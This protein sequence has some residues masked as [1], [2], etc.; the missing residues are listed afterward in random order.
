VLD[1]TFTHLFVLWSRIVN[2]NET[3]SRRL[4]MLLAALLIVAAGTS[5]PATIAASTPV[6]TP[7]PPAA[8]APEDLADP[9]GAF[10]EIDGARIYYVA[11]GPEDG[12]P[13]IL[14]HGLLGSTLTWTATTEALA[15][16][17]YRV[18]AFDQPPFGLSAKAS[19]LDYSVV[20]QA[21]RTIGLMDA[22]GIERAALVGHSGGGPIAGSV[23]ERY[24][25]RVSKLVLV[26]PAYLGLLFAPAGG[27]GSPAATPP[28]APDASPPV[29]RQ[30]SLGLFPVL[31]DPTND[32][33]SA[34]DQARLREA[35]ATEQA[36]MDQTTPA[37]SADQDPFRFTQIA[38]WE[39]GLL[40]HGRAWLNDPAI[41]GPNAEAITAP[42]LLIWGEGD[43]ISA[44]GDQLLALFS[45]AERV[46]VPGVG[47]FPMEEAPDAFNRAL[48]NFL[49]D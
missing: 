35:I 44:I 46:I 49:A 42:V 2:L 18:L 4:L 20:A 16:A 14:L 26:A 31:F 39:A 30:P 5:W 37:V 13:V 27:E 19:D 45:D 3:S 24:P 32:P 47:H 34:A 7:S 41:M 25:D 28:A 38:G 17:G 22:L 29:G 36:L 33:H 9:Q 10:I 6:A 21:D 48:L 12:P 1:E 11:R 43:Q 23:A 40:A 15:G 8:I